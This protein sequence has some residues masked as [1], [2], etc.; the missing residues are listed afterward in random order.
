MF[1]ITFNAIGDIL[2]LAQLVRDVALALDDARGAAPEIRRFSHELKFLAFIIEKAHRMAET[3]S[4]NALKEAILT[5]VHLCYIELANAGKLTPGFDG[6]LPV[7]SDISNVARARTALKKLQWHFSKASEAA[8]YAT[9]FHDIERRLILLI[10]AFNHQSLQRGFS[11]LIGEI[12][13]LEASAESDHM[14]MHNEIDRYTSRLSTELR[15]IAAGSIEHI[16]HDIERS[17][18]DQSRMF[19][20][21]IQEA[22]DSLRHGVV[23]TL[24]QE[25]HSLVPKFSAT[26]SAQEQRLVERTSDAIMRRLDPHSS[27]HQVERQRFLTALIPFAI[28]GATIVASTVIKPKWRTAALWAT[29]CALIIHILRLQFAPPVTVWKFSENV[30]ILIDLLGERMPIALQLCTSLELFHEFLSNYYT[31]HGRKGQFYVKSGFYELY[32]T[33]SSQ[34]LTFDGWSQNIRPG[35]QLEMGILQCYP[36]SDSSQ[37]AP[38]RCP[39]C[40]SEA[41]GEMPINSN[42][43]TCVGCTRSFTATRESPQSRPSPVAV[44]P[45]SDWVGCQDSVDLHYF[46]RIRVIEV[47]VFSATSASPE[48]RTVHPGMH[49]HFPYSPR[50]RSSVRRR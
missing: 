40:H 17:A 20:T 2:A 16:S 50:L 43:F 15:D 35:A 36:D 48:R 41:Y 30:I 22:R 33:E 34:A 47:G 14:F 7:N 19:I 37:S 32:S 9:R 13:D 6:L 10:V 25:I 12:N 44:K 4:D 39:W 42:R 5:E 3:S 38:V 1:P 26:F 21:A 27:V 8:T 29:I 46:V 11:R 49:H 45:L 31:T 28:L 18:G 24:R 23:L